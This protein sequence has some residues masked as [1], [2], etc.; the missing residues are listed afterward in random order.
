MPNLKQ[1]ALHRN[2][3]AS[4]PDLP[5]LQRNGIESLTLSENPWHCDCNLSNEAMPGWIWTNKELV[6][7]HPGLY[8]FENSTAENS[9]ALSILPS[10]S[11]LNV[12]TFFAQF[13]STFCPSATLNPQKFP[14]EIFTTEKIDEIPNGSPSTSIDFWLWAIVGVFV[15]FAVSFTILIVYFLRKR[16]YIVN[17][18]RPLSLAPSDGSSGSP[19]PLLTPDAL[20]IHSSGD[21]SFVRNQLAAP[22]E[23]Q[24]PHYQL[25]LLYRDLDPETREHMPE[26]YHAI[27]RAHQVIVLISENFLIKEWDY[28]WV[29]RTALHLYIQKHFKQRVIFIVKMPIPC[30]F[31]DLLQKFM[32]TNVLLDF[33]DPIFWEKLRTALPDKILNSSM[34]GT[35]S[36]G[37][38]TGCRSASPYSNNHY[39]YG[40]L[41]GGASQQSR[42]I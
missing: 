4:L 19:L 34:D 15:V 35:V 33:N 20:I 23:D 42:L 26:L 37:I 5:I 12:W 27:E 29:L 22:L 18:R 31:D 32:R 14:P 16:K 1:L 25:K 36:T 10:G 21:E 8:C 6:P 38:T 39:E 30:A 13:N 9:S 24:S 3:L 41:I 11:R 2:Q 7:D 28:S 17:N 40:S